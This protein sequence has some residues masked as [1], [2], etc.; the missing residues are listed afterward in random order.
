MERYRKYNPQDL[1]GGKKLA[2]LVESPPDFRPAPC[3]PLFFDLALNHVRF[4]SL[5][6]KLEPSD[7][8]Q[9]PSADNKSGLSGLVKGWFWGSKK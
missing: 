4:P 9:V 3:K 2:T 5:E 8:G 7:K 1:V 6:E